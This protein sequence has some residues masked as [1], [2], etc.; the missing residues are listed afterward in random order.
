LVHGD[1]Q[2]KRIFQDKLH[3]LYPEINVWIP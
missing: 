1:E 3:R 2:V